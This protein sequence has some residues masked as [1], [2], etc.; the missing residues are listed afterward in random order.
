MKRQ[1]L[2][3]YI[4]S[5]FL[6][7]LLAL[8]AASQTEQGVEVKDAPRVDP[9]S[10]SDFVE[11]LEFL[12]KAGSFSFTAE[13]EY[14]A[15]QG[16]G[17]KIEFG[18][19]KKVTVVRPDKVYADIEERDGTKKVFVF[20]GKDIY[21]SDLERNVYASVPRPGD[22]NQAIDYFTE[23]LQMPFQLGQLISSDVSEMVKKEIYAGGFVD[24]ATINGV[25][26][27]HLAFRTENIDLQVWIASEGDPLIMRFVIDYKNAPGEPQFRAMFK[28]WNFKPELSDSLFVFKPAE[29]M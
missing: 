27:D 24:Q 6:F 20:D 4:C 9:E 25:L 8:P 13:T 3:M 12:S 2:K 15:L 7:L 21:F 1:S 17:Q 22:I 26:C 14:D 19:T 11:S 23:D 28:D 16:N 29:K 10:L 18:G 5:S